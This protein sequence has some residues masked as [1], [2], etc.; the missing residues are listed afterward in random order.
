MTTHSPRRVAVV[1]GGASGIGLETS[2]LLASRGYDIA[3]GD[4]D[5]EGATSTAKAIAAAGGTA[6]AFEID[7]AND[8]SI[9]TFR[10]EVVDAQGVPTLLANVAGW[11]MPGPFLDNTDEYRHKVIAIN[12][13]GPIK[14]AQEFLG[15]MVSEGVPGRIVNVSSEAGRV[16]TAGEIVYSAAKGGIIAFTKSLALEMARH[17]MTVN[18]VAPGP[19]D[20]PLLQH[21]SERKQT[22]LLRAIPLRRL[23]QPREIAAVIAFFASPEAD[24]ITGQVLSVSGGLTMC[25]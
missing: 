21:I 8:S 22:A 4:I 3:I 9:T 12:L 10:K 20:T 19:T 17:G 7:L 1:T 15:P 14:V 25:D 6:R 2:L 23:A 16:G 18:C 13:L 24:Y 5:L 11:D